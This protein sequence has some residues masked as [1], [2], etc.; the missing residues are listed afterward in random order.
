MT[1]PIYSTLMKVDACSPKYDST[2]KSLPGFEPDTCMYSCLTDFAVV[3]GFTDL[4]RTLGDKMTPLDIQVYLSLIRAAGR[5]K[6]VRAAF[7]VVTKLQASG[8]SLDIAACNCVL[9]VG[10]SAGDMRRARSLM[11]GMQGVGSLD[12]VSYNALLKGYRVMRDLKGAPILDE[13]EAAG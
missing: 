4:S 12:V 3:C 8:V 6:D 5:D 11:E 9:D 1:I 10:V 13:M 7:T 2:P